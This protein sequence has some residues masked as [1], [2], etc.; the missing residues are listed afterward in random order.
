MKITDMITLDEFAWYFIN[1]SPLLL[2][3]MNRGNKWKFKS[4]SIRSMIVYDSS[5]SLSWYCPV[6]TWKGCPY[7][8]VSTTLQWIPLGTSNKIS[9]KSSE[10]SLRHWSERPIKK[11]KKYIYIQFI[12]GL[13]IST[14]L[15]FFNWSFFSS[16][17]S[18]CSR[19]NATIHFWSLSAAGH[20]VLYKFN[21]YVNLYNKVKIF[22]SGWHNENKQHY[23]IF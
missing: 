13:V 8:F 18:S 23:I 7:C 16:C 11:R 12:P 10:L 6:F 3:E 4:N 22:I 19:V 1:F 5:S 21:K 9:D 17:F 14:C 2:C 20:R 15:Y